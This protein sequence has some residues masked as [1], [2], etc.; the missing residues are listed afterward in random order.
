MDLAQLVAILEFV[1]VSE[2][3]R[4][5]FVAIDIKNLARQE[6]ETDVEFQGERFKVKYRPNIVTT[7]WVKSM[8]RAE[9]DKDED[10]MVGELVR[11]I[12][13]WELEDDGIKLPVNQDTFDAL[14][15]PLTTAIIQAVM[16]SATGS[17]DEEGK[18][19]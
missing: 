6:A 4:R 13:D 1:L 2:F 5:I 9:N 14:P 16:R 12:A 19:R 10:K 17:T 3:L 11:L 15:L 8:R 7:K 18:A